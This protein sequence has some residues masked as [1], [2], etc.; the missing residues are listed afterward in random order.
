M[1][2]AEPLREQ[3]RS[4]APFLFAAETP[5]ALDV[6]A[7]AVAPRGWHALVRHE[8]GADRDGYFALCCACHHAT[9]ATYV[10]TDVDSKIRGHLWR[11]SMSAASR[12]RR[13]AF[14]L[15]ARRWS[16]DGISAR[17]VATPSGPVSGHDGEWLAVLLGALGA[18]AAA[19]EPVDELAAAIDGELAREAAALRQAVAAD[20]GELD[21]ARLAAVMTH[22]AGDVDQG[23]S[24]W[25]ELPA[26]A[27]WRERF[28]RLAHENTTAYDGAFQQAARIYRATLSPEGHRNYPLRQAKALRR[29][30]ALLLP[31]APFLDDWG[32]VVATH[33][34]LRDDERAEVL[35]QLIEGC[36]RIAG[37]S[38]YQ[39]AIAGIAAAGSLDRLAKRLPNAARK[40]LDDAALR[41]AIAVPRASFEA[42]MRKKVIAAKID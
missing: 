26:L 38:G 27:P 25:S 10:P 14:A 3:A 16:V 15:A 37:Q 1:I 41:R 36:R 18:A 8:R 11:E 42:A 19:G 33:A 6:D 12:R 28:A 23:I 24:Y 22:N 4:T 35:A 21:A 13:T 34:A 31:M 9:V 39:R 20:G 2:D 32:G 7:A 30:P 40:G 5:D 17:V 29:D